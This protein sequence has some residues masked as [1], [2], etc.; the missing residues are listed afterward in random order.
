MDDAS[1]SGSRYCRLG[2]LLLLIP[3]VSGAGCTPYLGTTY[4]SYLRHIRENNDPNIRYIAYA[5]LGSPRLYETE[6]EKAEAVAAL[7]A[8]F[9]EGREPIAVRAAI[10]RS[11]GNLRDVRARGVVL[12]AANDNDNAVI[13]V[14]ACRALGKVGL[15]ED[16]T[17]LARIMMVDKL[18]DCRIA[19]IESL[20]A[21][22]AE[23]PRMYQILLDGMDHD[24]PAIR[25]ESLRALRAITNKDLGVDP[26]AWRR[27]LEPKIA[28]MTSAAAKPGAPQ[29]AAAVGDQQPR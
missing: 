8:K 28:A 12:K 25:L 22:K 26:A 29:Q 13:R 23:D 10:I 19:A 21:L 16:A 15:P 14:E 1:I 18:E 24:D 3:L 9:D 5:K 4:K 17:L 7:L 6:A 11:L 27:E 20:G 2:G